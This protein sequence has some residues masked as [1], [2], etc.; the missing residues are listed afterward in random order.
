M[1]EKGIAQGAGTLEWYF[2]QKQLGRIVKRL[3]R[4]N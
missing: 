2:P 3:T 1:F 4:K